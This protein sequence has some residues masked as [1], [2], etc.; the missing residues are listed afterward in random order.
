MYHVPLAFKCIYGGSDEDGKKGVGEEGKEFRLPGL[1][2]A[3]NLVLC[4]ESD[5]DLKAIVGRFVEAY[6]RRGLK[7]SVGKSTVMVLSHEGE[8]E[9]E[10]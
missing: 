4:S 3:D 7:V 2:Y 5:E 9:C 6:R 10:V 8:L 1:L